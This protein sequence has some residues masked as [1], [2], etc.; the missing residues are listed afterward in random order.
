[1]MMASAG[2]PQVELESQMKV[3]AHLQAVELAVEF[4]ELEMFL[5]DLQ[6][7]LI[8]MLYSAEQMHSCVVL[9]LK[10]VAQVQVWLLFRNNPPTREWV[11]RE[12][13]LREV[14]KI[15]V[16]LQPQVKFLT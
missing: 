7:P 5:Q 11:Q 10:P 6:T 8:L 1:M 13:V 12:Q 9:H 16:A 2:Q 15:E 14:M 4:A 3:A